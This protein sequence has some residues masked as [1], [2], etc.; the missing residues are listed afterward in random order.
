MYQLTAWAQ[1][2]VVDSILSNLVCMFAGR[3]VPFYGQED[4][5]SQYAVAAQGICLYPASSHCFKEV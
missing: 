1:K 3:P 5:P 2:P 4:Q